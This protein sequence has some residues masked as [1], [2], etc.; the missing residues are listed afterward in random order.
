MNF[1][2]KVFYEESERFA[3][4]NKIA[5]METSALNGYNCILAMELIIQGIKK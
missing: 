1:I 4:D 2:N 5:F 3:R